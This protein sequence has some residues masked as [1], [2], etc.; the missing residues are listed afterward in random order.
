M[1]E[2]KTMCS[3]VKALEGLREACGS[4]RVTDGTVTMEKTHFLRLF[5]D[6]TVGSSG[7]SAT[8]LVLFTAYDGVI[9]QAFARE[10]RTMDIGGGEDA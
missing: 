1:D 2:L 6:F 7:I 8:P 9:F 3:S 4:V 10:L 5:R